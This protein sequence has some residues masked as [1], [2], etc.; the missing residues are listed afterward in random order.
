MDINI[1]QIAI[2]AILVLVGG[3]SSS[4]H[5]EAQANAFSIEEINKRASDIPSVTSLLIQQNGQLLSEEYFNGVRASGHANIKSASKSIISLLVGIAIDHDFLSGVDQPIGPFFEEYFEKHPDSVKQALT[6]KDLL[7]MRAGLETTSFHNYGRWVTSD[8][9]VR[10]ALDQP[11]EAKPGGDMVYSTGTSH[12]LSVIITRAAGMSTRDFA[13]QY[14]FNPMDIAAGGW[15][16]DPQGYYMGGNN[17]ALRPADMM[18]IGQMVLNGGS[19]RGEQIVSERWLED[20]F[21]TYTRSNF[22]PYD[23][24]YMWWKKPVGAFQVRFAWGFGGQY[25]FLIPE[26]DA[27]V[28]L[29]GSL[30]NAD[31]SRSYKEPVF[32]LLREDILPFLQN[33]VSS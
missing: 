11:M 12:L 24:G 2:G 17:L 6:L 25:I 16:R 15:D 3:L 8:N 13:R 33:R 30:Q 28:V 20:S 19:F 14:L 21:R 9:W 7:T 31:Q 22:N 27:V 10:Y 1:K 5:L 32:D 4:Q 29:T 26:L 23:Y 18:K